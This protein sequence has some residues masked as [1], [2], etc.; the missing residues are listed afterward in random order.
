MRTTFLTLC[1]LICVSLTAC[2]GISS[3]SDVA[4]HF[5]PDEYVIQRFT[6]SEIEEFVDKRLSEAEMMNKTISPDIMFITHVFNK[7]ATDENPDW[8]YIIQFRTEDNAKEFESFIG[9]N[10]ENKRFGSILIYGDSPIIS[11]IE[12]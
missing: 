6:T 10:R 3:V 9:N 12:E 11:E 1:L 2:G 5:D 4:D 7:Q 8:A